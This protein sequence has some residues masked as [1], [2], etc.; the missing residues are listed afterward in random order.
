LVG[1]R[2]IVLSPG[3][4]F[5]A[6]LH[7]IGQYIDPSDDAPL[8]GPLAA[9][10]G[11]DVIVA[12]VTGPALKNLLAAWPEKEREFA[13]LGDVRAVTLRVGLTPDFT[14]TVSADFPDGP[15]ARRGRAAMAG[16]RTWATDVLQSTV[17]KMGKDE[18]RFADALI[19]ALK[20]AG[21]PKLD[22]KSVKYA[23]GMKGE[24]F[25]AVGEAAG[26]AAV[27]RIRESAE[28]MKAANYL[29][30]IGLAIHNVHDVN[31]TFPFKERAKEIAHPG[32]SW[33]V[34]LLPF[35][36]QDDL[37]RQFKL[38]EPWDSENN[39][40]LIEKMPKLFAPP[41]GVKANPGHTFLRMFDGP[42]TISQ[43]RSFADVV[44]GTSNT[45][46]VVEAAESEIWTKPDEL[47]YDPKKPLPK[48]GGHFAD[49]F[50]ILFADGSVRF[51]ELPVS[52][53]ILRSWITINGGE[54]VVKPDK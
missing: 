43:A 53:K 8:S 51:I 50:H 20:D 48:L 18:E 30:Q 39:K 38:D 12:G 22:G 36:E 49:G 2:S 17:R 28:R 32:L 10:A 4:N 42:G 44:D 27:A 13:A 25:V 14:C 15:S 45:L 26:R 47:E 54:D 7:L 9:A 24:S 41:S 35:I 37:Y 31:G 19:A 1:D 3:R 33:R 34:A 16:L 23:V 11:K 40:K 46:M 6:W 29:K 21:E 5:V 52:E